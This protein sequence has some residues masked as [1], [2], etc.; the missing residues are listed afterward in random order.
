MDETEGQA[1][2]KLIFPRMPF[3]A[4]RSIG[5]K[6]YSNAYAQGIGRHTEEE[7]LSLG[8][9]DIRAISNFLG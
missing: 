8:E 2:W 5:K 6:V 1:F 7:A 4:I 3:I 9:G